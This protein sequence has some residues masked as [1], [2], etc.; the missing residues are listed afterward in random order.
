VEAHLC[1]TGATDGTVRLWDLRRVDGDAE[2]SEWDLSDVLEETD[3]DGDCTG[4]SVVVDRPPTAPNGTRLRS[5]T[6]KKDT[7]G[8]CIRVLEGHSK[9]VTALYFE[10][11]TLVRPFHP[12]SNLVM[13]KKTLLGDRGI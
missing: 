9:A 8:P 10:N 2:T 13:K 1:A 3:E 4:D 5:R 7:P 12:L 6:P 11:D